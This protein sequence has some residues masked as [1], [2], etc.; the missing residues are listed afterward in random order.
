ML[1]IK[2]FLNEMVE[3]KVE[4][5]RRE[6]ILVSDALTKMEHLDAKSELWLRTGPVRYT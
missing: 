2:E 5:I 4:H 6:K 3:F 1:E